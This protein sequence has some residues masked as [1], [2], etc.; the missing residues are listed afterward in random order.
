MSRGNEES[1]YGTSI[2]SVIEAAMRF[3]TGVLVAGALLGACASAK[4]DDAAPAKPAREIASGGA[5]LRGGGFRMDVQ[6]GRPLTQQPVR[7]NKVVAKP[8]G[9]VTP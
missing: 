3:F 4:E 1:S 2:I 6:L 7:A 8:N 5:T 9:V